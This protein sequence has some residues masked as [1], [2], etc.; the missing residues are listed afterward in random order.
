MYYSMA[1]HKHHLIGSASNQLNLD[2][3][4]GIDWCKYWYIPCYD[5]HQGQN[6]ILQWVDLHHKT[7]HLPWKNWITYSTLLK[8][9]LPL[10]NP[11]W[12]GLLERVF[13]RNEVCLT[14]FSFKC[15]KVP[16]PDSTLSQASFCLKQ[17]P[18]RWQTLHF[19]RKLIIVSLKVV[20]SMQYFRVSQNVQTGKLMLATSFSG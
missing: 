14:K 7:H 18:K 13:W 10:L 9:V 4:H 5:N 16:R 19:A 20:V 1:G 11:K 17:W 8:K 6:S 12:C 3:A 2:R 15:A